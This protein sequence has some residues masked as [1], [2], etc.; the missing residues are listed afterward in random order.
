MGSLPRRFGSPLLLSFF[1]LTASE[2][3]TITVGSRT[4][5]FV[6]SLPYVLCFFFR[7][8]ISQEVAVIEVLGL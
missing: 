6:F 7:F 1:R 3:K 4:A 8:S 2:L 5:V